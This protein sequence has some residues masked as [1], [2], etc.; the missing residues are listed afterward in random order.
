MKAKIFLRAVLACALACFLARCSRKPAPPP[1]ERLTIVD[2]T[3][4]EVSVPQPLERVV[5]LASQPAEVIAA[6]GAHDKVVGVTRHVLRDAITRMVYKGKPSVGEILSP[7]VE[8]IL[9]LK[10]QLVVT[11]GAWSGAREAASGIAERLRRYD[12]AL[13]YIDCFPDA[14]TVLRDTQTLGRLFHKER[15]AK[16]YVAFFKKYLDL[17]KQRTQRLEPSKRTRVYM[18]AAAYAV[19]HWGHKMVAAAGGLDIAAD[20]P[21]P[22][23]RL[24]AEWILGKDPQV[25]VARA[26][27]A[28]SLGYGVVEEQN[29]G[30]QRQALLNRPGWAGVRAVRDGKVY[31]LAFEVC[32]APRAPIGILYMAKWFYPELFE[33]LDPDAVHKEFLREFFGFQEYE[34]MFVYP[35]D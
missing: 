26:M 9:E 18:G 11:V 28:R 15:R 4:A 3:G 2:S 8:R 5:V 24:S 13:A 14:D 19:T 10:P 1:R 17:I 29:A 34:G 6:L 7:S 21:T 35:A 12:I 27:P 30:A 31:L 32:S 33:D 16:E 25:I 20:V 23:A 22:W